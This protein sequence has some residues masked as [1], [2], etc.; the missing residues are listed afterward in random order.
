MAV[1]IM[2]GENE[3]RRPETDSLRPCVIDGVWVTYEDRRTIWEAIDSSMRDLVNRCYQREGEP[4]IADY[5]QAVRVFTLS[6][7][8]GSGQ[9][10][11]HLRVYL[12]DSR[13]LA[14]DPSF[15]V[16]LP[17]GIPC[18]LLEALTVRGWGIAAS[19]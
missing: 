9:L 4:S 16:V 7:Q 17:T 19:G 14:E 11:G 8:G 5:I 13:S 3:M 15:R 12:K 10:I 6:R 2:L 18:A 1:R